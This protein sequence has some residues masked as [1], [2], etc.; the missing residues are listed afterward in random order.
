MSAV[1][2]E[3]VRQTMSKQNQES[4]VTGRVESPIAT[5]TDLNQDYGDEQSRQFYNS[6]EE[7][8]NRMSGIS[9]R[10]FRS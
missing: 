2:M 10:S 3:S 8:K 7:R 5:P 9:E 1:S 4:H 6:Q